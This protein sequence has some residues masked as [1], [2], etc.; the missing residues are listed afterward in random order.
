MRIVITGHKGQLGQA[1]QHTFAGHDILGIDLPEHDITDPRATADAIVHWQPDLVIH[2]AAMTDVDG[3]Q[4]NPDLAFRVNTLGTH[5]V[6]LASARA[7]ADL[8]HISTNEVFDGR[9][10]RPYYEW[11]T[12]SPLSVY[13]RSKAGAEFYV[14]NLLPNYYIVRTSWLYARGGSN[15]VTKIIAAADRHGALRVVIDEISAPT[16]APDLAAAIGQLVETRHY[17]VYHLT[18]AGFCSRYDWAQEILRL[19]GRGHVPIERITTDQWPRPAPPPLY[20]PMVNFAAAALGI[21]LRPWPDALRAYF[22]GD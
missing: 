21:T 11:D 1:L 14:R 7:G 12:P 18:N 10:G 6:V 3:C 20:A 5:N 9:L 2:P 17:G 4:Q 22:S 13:A 8:V 16:Y 19:A 15:F